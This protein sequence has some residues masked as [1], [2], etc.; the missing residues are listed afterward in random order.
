MLRISK[1]LDYALIVLVHL[2]SVKRGQLLSARDIAE[3]YGLPLPITAGILK[4]LAKNE[5]VKSIRGVR[6]GYALSIVPREFT[7]S[8]IVEAIEGPL[9]IADCI[10]VKNSRRH[11]DCDYVG[12]CPVRIPVK[13]LHETLE[14]VLGGI[15]LAEL[16]SWQAPSPGGARARSSQA[17]IAAAPVES[18]AVT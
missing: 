3:S 12:C 17:R 5:I 7:L 10:H 1:K 18:E 15:T 14:R 11:K 16:S 2:A 13:K 6:G 8:Q 4:T 9:E